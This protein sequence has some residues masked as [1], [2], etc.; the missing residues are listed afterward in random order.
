[1][2]EAKQPAWTH[3]TPARADLQTLIALIAAALAFAVTAFT[4]QVLNDGDTF[5]HIAAGSRMLAERA[6]LYHDPFSYTF[7]GAAWEAHEW[8]AE[9]AMAAAYQAGGWSALLFLVA[10]AA[11]ATAGLLAHHLGRWM[12]WPM[13]AIVTLIALCCMTAS[14]LARPHILALPL[15][16]LWTAGLVIAR[17]QNRAP[18][19]ALLPLMTLWVNIH[20]SFLLGLALAAALALEALATTEN[21]MVVFRSWGI[22]CAGAF[23]SALINP[24]FLAGILFPLDMMG[25]SSLAS[26]SEWQPTDF[27]RLQP[28]ELAIMA[29]I[30]FF[31][32]RG[33]K[34]A[35]LRA[36]LV[37]GLLHIA[38]Q[39]QRHQIVF[40]LTAPLLLAPS[41]ALASIPPRAV[42]SAGTRHLAAIGSNAAIALIF[43]L[44]LLRL[45][46]VLHR[47]DSAVAP[48]EALQHVPSAVRA[49]HVL[50]DYSFGGYL[51]F[52]GVKPFVDSRAE[53]YGDGF[54]VRYGKL[55]EPDPQ[56]VKR[57]IRAYDVGWTIFAKH[58]RVIGIMDATAGWHRIYADNFAVVHIRDK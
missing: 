58:S 47:S 39:H 53:L 33:V 22:F 49:E 27:S 44:A 34:I 16:E 29:A 37:L 9:V 46:V 28:L 31:V 35:P 4:P 30:Y 11:A 57:V 26:V 42:L 41:F 2:D 12:N 18:P 13:Q 36:L 3:A 20:G 51:I 1:M 23:M 45:L 15:L 14:L 8:F 7:A 25:I 40:A 17:S 32:T 19:L 10:L 5:F 54:L 24:H 38:L 50:N 55:I 56:E 43:A 6:I 52:M 48:I 21:R